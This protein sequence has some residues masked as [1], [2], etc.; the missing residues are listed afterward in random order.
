MNHMT[1]LP[2]IYTVG[3]TTVTRVTEMVISGVPPEIYF[4]GTWDPSFF[5][6]RTK[7][8]SQRA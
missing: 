8:P 3:D 1:K 2:K 7:N 4:P 6:K 5:W